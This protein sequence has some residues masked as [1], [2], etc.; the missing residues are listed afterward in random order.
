MHIKGAGQ[1]HKQMAKLVYLRDAVG[2]DANI[3]IEIN[4]CISTAWARL[5]NYSPQ[6]YDRPNAQLLLTVPLLQEEVVGVMPS[7]CTTWTLR[8]E[9]I[10]NLCAAHHKPLLRVMGFGRNKRAVYE[11]LSYRDALE[12]TNCELIKPTMRSRQ[13]RCARALARQG[14]IL[15]PRRIVFERSGGT[16]P[17]EADQPPEHRGDR[18]REHLNELGALLHKGKRRKGFAYGMEFKEKHDCVTVVKDVRRWHLGVEK[19]AGQFEDTCRRED[20]RESD[21][22]HKMRG[23]YI[24]SRKRRAKAFEDSRMEM[25][26]I[27][28]RSVPD[29]A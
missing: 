28:S 9:E 17:K 23:S 22:R 16:G 7:G 8:P 21:R 2:V 11:T 12:M 19:R 1:R 13:V 29:Q 18:I 10:K 4:R 15:V 20:K 5:R 14:E 3:P 24:E 27:V 25:D 26:K 6:L